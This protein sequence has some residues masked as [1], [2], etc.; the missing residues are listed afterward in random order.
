MLIMSSTISSCSYDPRDENNFVRINPISAVQQNGQYDI[1]YLVQDIVTRDFGYTGTSPYQLTLQDAHMVLEIWDSPSR[2]SKREFAQL[3]F[4]GRQWEKTLPSSHDVTVLKDTDTSQITA[5]LRH[6]MRRV[7]EAYKSFED[8]PSVTTRP[9]VSVEGEKS[10]TTGTVVNNYITCGHSDFGVLIRGLEHQMFQLNQRLAY[11][12]ELVRAG[13]PIR[14][15]ETSQGISRLEETIRQLHD[16]VDGLQRDI[17]QLHDQNAALKGLKKPLD[18]LAKDVPAALREIRFEIE[19]LRNALGQLSEKSS[20]TQAHIIE[21]MQSALRKMESQLDPLK[22]SNQEL[23]A[24]RDSLKQANE[25]LKG[26]AALKEREIESLQLKDRKQQE[27]LEKL[28]QELAEANEGKEQLATEIRALK[29]QL[30]GFEALKAQMAPLRQQ[31]EEAQRT[32]RATLEANESLRKQLQ[33]AEASNE[34]FQRLAATAQAKLE[35]AN[36]L[37]DRNYLDL[38]EARSNID[39]LEKQVAASEKKIASH[40]KELAQ[41]SEKHQADEQHILTL[42][43]MR[44]QLILENSQLKDAIAGLERLLQTSKSTDQAAQRTIAEL[45][46]A[47][48]QKEEELAQEKQAT[49]TAQASTEKANAALKQLQWELGEQQERTREAEMSRAYYEDLYNGIAKKYGAAALELGDLKRDYEEYRRV[50]NGLE[51]EQDK[52]IQELEVQ[53]RALQSQLASAQEALQNKV[54]PSELVSLRQQVEEQKSAKE[55]SDRLLQKQLEEARRQLTNAEESRRAAEA[56]NVLLER[57][58]QQLRQEIEELQAEIQRLRKLLK[59][60]ERKLTQ[61]PTPPTASDLREA[62][63]LPAAVPF[64]PVIPQV[65]QTAI[66]QGKIDCNKEWATSLIVNFALLHFETTPLTIKNVDSEIT[67]WYESQKFD[68][69]LT[70]VV[71]KRAVINQLVGR[72]QGYQYSNQGTEKTIGELKLLISK[73]EKDLNFDN[74]TTLDDVFGKTTKAY[75]AQSLIAYEKELETLLGYLTGV[76][77]TDRQTPTVQKARERLEWIRSIKACLVELK[78]TKIVVK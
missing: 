74:M 7:A 21:E 13:Q 39:E 51:N 48:K 73:I 61:D 69:S 11:L 71:N 12:E 58:N 24:E 68:A 28:R 5:R 34:E 65:I 23:Q 17:Q 43:G 75:L 18:T 60:D 37:A 19:Q 64:V 56:K 72:K 55:I 76:K 15:G 45:Q 26:V 49:K 35:D 8:S 77:L 41:A 36:R 50:S 4:N 29:E 1:S 70:D 53:L 66:A 30:E 25:D 20:G 42:Q 47:L 32:Q 67:Q 63:L 9:A 46:D 57:Q 44:E 2:I 40:E 14:T 33:A 52:R 16:R 3:Y 10:S 59:L 54:D 22:K 27:V 38:T 78:K 62:P 31:L 6:T